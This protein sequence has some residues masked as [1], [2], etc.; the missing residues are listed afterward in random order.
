MAKE[1]SALN[2]M[3][4]PEISQQLQIPLRTLNRWRSQFHKYID[5]EIRNGKRYHPE[6]SIEVFQ[7]IHQLR[8]ENKTF[9]EICEHLSEQC[10]T[11]MAVDSIKATE[12][13]P[14]NEDDNGNL[15]KIA[16]LEKMVADLTETVNMLSDQYADLASNHSQL[17]Q[18]L[19]TAQDKWEVL[20][21]TMEERERLT[22]RWMDERDLQLIHTLR[23]VNRM[24]KKK[25][26]KLKWLQSLTQ[27]WTS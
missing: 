20:S 4:L 18:H 15:E 24:K 17:Q 10:G 21:Q 11:A 14:S 7:T 1:V 22:Q 16:Q 6:T 9:R 19:L 26:K 27:L 25:Q 13:T 12:A 8:Q 23:E 3:L 2:W 5:S